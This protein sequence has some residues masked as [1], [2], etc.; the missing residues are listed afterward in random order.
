MARPQAWADVQRKGAQVMLVGDISGSMQARDVAPDRFSAARAAADAFLARLPEGA[1]VGAVAF[2]DTATTL[3]P[4]THD[5][6]AVRRALGGPAAAGRHG[7]GRRHR[8]GAHEPATAGR[9]GGAIVL[10][11]D[12]KATGAPIR[13]RP[14]AGPRPR[15][16]RSTPSRWG[17]SAASWRSPTS[18]AGRSRSRCHRIRHALRE[19]ARVSGGRFVGAGDTERLVAAYEHLGPKSASSASGAS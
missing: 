10:L 15:G 13:W 3:T 16:S 8:R 4:P 2:N 9:R 19:I 12:G 17:P 18:T 6:A 14:R 1:R 11:S 7:D 5:R